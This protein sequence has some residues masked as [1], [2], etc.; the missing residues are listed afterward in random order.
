M[1]ILVEAFILGAIGGFVPGAVLTLLLVS[2]L[3]GGLTAGV[4]AFWWSMLAEVLIAGS[5]LLIATQLP[6]GQS[7]FNVIG[8]VGGGF[9]FYFSWKIFQL[10]SITVHDG[11]LLFTAPKIFLISATNAPLYIFWSTI[12]FPLIWQLATIWSLPVAAVSYF[13]VFEVGW[14]IT[15]FITILLFVYARPMLSNE[16]I[17]H[18][19]FIFLALVF[20]AFGFRLL[21]TSL[22]SLF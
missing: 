12:C 21:I 18:R 20:A 15:T 17:M 9:L 16:R 8:V 2:V 14:A 6:I 5:L 4:R 10:R 1:R 13:V 11:A 3:Q 22:F 19:I 7:F